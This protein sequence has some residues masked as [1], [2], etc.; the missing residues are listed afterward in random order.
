MVRILQLPVIDPAIQE[1]ENRVWHQTEDVLDQRSHVWVTR[2]SI[3]MYSWGQLSS[4]TPCE[5]NQAEADIFVVNAPFTMK[6][7]VNAE[8]IFSVLCNF[9]MSCSCIITNLGSNP[10]GRPVFSAE[11]WGRR[12]TP[13]VSSKSECC[14][15]SRLHPDHL[16]PGANH[17]HTL[18]LPLFHGNSAGSHTYYWHVY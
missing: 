15:H 16:P 11:P 10:P 3:R 2:L 14:P 17:T 12:S 4:F 9:W 8:Y 5:R 7:D 6:Y 18:P 1:V 13:A